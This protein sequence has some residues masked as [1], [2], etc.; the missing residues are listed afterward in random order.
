[1]QLLSLSSF[2]SLD[3]TLDGLNKGKITKPVFLEAL[4]CA[5][6]CVNG[7]CAAAEKSGLSIT[8]DI[9]S[10]IKKREKIPASPSVVA[11]ETY[12][13]QPVEHKTYS[14]E[15]ISK[16]M[17]KI[18]K[19]TEEDELNCGGCGYATCRDLASALLSGDAE[20]SMCVSYMRKIAMRKAAALLRCMPSAMVMVDSELKVVEA[21]DAFMRMFCGEMYEVFA[22]R[23]DGL[24]GAAIDR[25]I[26]FSDI[27][28]QA[29]QTGKD[30]HKEHFPVENKLY[31]ISAFT[32][33][34]NEI[35]GAII[36]DVTRSEM[37]REKIAQ[38]AREVITKNVATVQEIAC[39]LGEHMVE[40]ELLLN[41]IAEGYE[42]ESD[43]H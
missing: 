13:A 29:L 35:A 25:I 3:K 41:S 43:V 15:E 24:A 39:L 36:T 5:G 8:S 21:N 7:P 23:Q 31:D 32:I 12:S 17:K 27:F 28:S 6:G 30:I 33:E 11:K 26:D 22:A 34:E 4:S 20:P 18:G 40:T 16:A 37:N 19:H 9:L 2:E 38:K 14:L 1:V 10:K 42:G